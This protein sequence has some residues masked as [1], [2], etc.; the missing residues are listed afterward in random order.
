M[1]T[2]TLAFTALLGATLLSTA[3]GDSRLGKLS[4]GISKDSV[5]VLMKADAP[6]RTQSF[7]TGG[8]LWEVYLYSRGAA[9]PADTIAWKK[10]SPVVF[11][12]GR[13]A[14]W[15][16]GWCKKQAP[17]LAVPLPPL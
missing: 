1:N 5:A 7:L 13:V 12:D 2:K 4:A 15:G 17:K 11:A 8:K 6:H 3:C 10:L 9:E 14:G 16:W